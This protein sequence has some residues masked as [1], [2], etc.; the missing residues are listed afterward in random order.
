[1]EFEGKISIL[2]LHRHEIEKPIDEQSTGSV[3]PKYRGVDARLAQYSSNPT[4]Q[5]NK[6]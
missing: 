3:V 4:E 1:M 6:R 2:S 5:T